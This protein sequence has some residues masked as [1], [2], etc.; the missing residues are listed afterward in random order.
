ML[1]G[2]DLLWQAYQRPPVKGE[3][4]TF[5]IAAA[6]CRSLRLA[7]SSSAPSFSTVTCDMG[8][9]CKLPMGYV[10]ETTTGSRCGSCPDAL[11]NA[12]LA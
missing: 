7:R 3:H 5:V 2:I 4:G 11:A 1:P 12:A 6:R 9:M 8:Y 10:Y